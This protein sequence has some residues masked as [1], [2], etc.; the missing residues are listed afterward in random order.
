V[1]SPAN[2]QIVERAALRLDIIFIPTLWL[3]YW[4]IKSHHESNVLKIRLN[5][6]ILSIYSKRSL[7]LGPVDFYYSPKV[8]RL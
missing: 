1:L 8:N 6:S 2:K 4:E 5:M 7:I 3:A